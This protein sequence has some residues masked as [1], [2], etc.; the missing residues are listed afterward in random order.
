MAD[1]QFGRD[2]D[3]G[4]GR[5]LGSLIHDATEDVSTLIRGEIELAKIEVKQSAINA[6]AGSVMFLVAGTF[7][8]LALI[9]LLIALAYAFVALGIPR[10][11]AFLLVA[12]I[13]LVIGGILGYLG[14]RKVK[15][16]GPPERTIEAGKKAVA[17]VRPGHDAP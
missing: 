4:R 17:A 2:D 5:S 9:M 14:Y 16:L 15:K 3:G 13:L 7:A 10:G 11:F 1:P 8:F 12:V 6:A